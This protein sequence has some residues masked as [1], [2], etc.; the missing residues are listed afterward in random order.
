MHLLNGFCFLSIDWLIAIDN[1][2]STPF[3]FTQNALSLSARGWLSPTLWIQIT[4][5]AHALLGNNNIDTKS[6]LSAGC[7]LLCALTKMRIAWKLY[8]PVCL[9]PRRNSSAQVWQRPEVQPTLFMPFF[10]FARPG[11]LNIGVAWLQVLGE[12]CTR[13]C[14]LKWLWFLQ[15]LRL[16]FNYC[17]VLYPNQLST[18]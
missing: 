10:N 16:I 2:R 4:R 11:A 12:H 15:T 17:C 1:M 8:F 5:A 7:I 14:I 18:F 3:V 9:S 13:N 6:H